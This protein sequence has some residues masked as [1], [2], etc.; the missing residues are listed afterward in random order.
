MEFLVAPQDAENHP[1]KIVLLGIGFASLAVW[2]T[3]ASGFP[4]GGFLVVGFS[5]IAAIPFL[6]HL[7]DYEAAN[8]P[9]GSPGGAAYGTDAAQAAATM[10]SRNLATITVLAALFFGLV[11]GYVF[12][13]VYLP[14]KQ[15]SSLFDAQFR[16]LAA[17]NPTAGRANAPVFGAD[18][19]TAFQVIFFH[20]IQ[21]EGIVLF[22]SAIYGAG[23]IAI[24]A[25]NASVIATFLAVV[26]KRFAG[27]VPPGSAALIAGLGTGFL[28]ILPHAFFELSAYLTMAVA[29]SLLSLAVL[30][31]G[32]SDQDVFIALFD[33]A[34]LIALSIV[35]LAFAAVIESN[36]L[37]L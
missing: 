2:L 6:I 35:L 4:Q 36:A 33:A 32:Q 18:P 21:V 19:L 17:I 9:G 29:G 3:T 30:R 22:F 1:W 12:W 13:Q 34:K 26:A 24:L 23:A 31:S 14:D 28:G 10:F 7:F 5:S 27:D 37:V 8:E 15:V 25:W 11:A 16:E 20:N